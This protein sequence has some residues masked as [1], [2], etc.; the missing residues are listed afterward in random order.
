MKFLLLLFIFL[1]SLFA[2]QSLQSL[3]NKSFSDKP[4]SQ[5][6]PV[7]MVYKDMLAF[8]ENSQD[9]NQLLILGSI[10][11]NGTTEADS[12]GD[13]IKKDPFLA[14]NYLLKAINKGNIK[15]LSV[16]AGFYMF[17]EDMRK[18]DPKLKKAEEYLKEAYKKGDNE[19]STLLSTLYFEKEIPDKGLEM[20]FNASNKQD[21]NADIALA[22][23]FKDGLIVKQKQI[24]KADM[25]TAEFYLN[26]ACSNKNKSEKINNLCFNSNYVSIENR[27]K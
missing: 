27:N 6:E 11:V 22:F 14:E 7:K 12:V 25:P 24:I 21:A 3:T 2:T 1:N 20:L 23:I 16:L 17:H 4:S 8:L 9:S 26:K 13:T 19:A 10:Y 18:L 15:A 5:E